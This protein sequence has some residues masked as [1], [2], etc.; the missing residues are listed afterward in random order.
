MASSAFTLSLTV[1]DLPVRRG[2]QIILSG[3]SF[4]LS[5]GEALVV[6]GPNGAGKSSLLRS[7]AGFGPAAR[8]IRFSRDGMPVD[9]DEAV[10]T[11]VHYLGHLNGLSPALSVSETLRFW[12]GHLGDGGAMPDL[13]DRFD[14]AHL[15][16]RATRHLSAGQAR[17]LAIAR[18]VIAPRPLWLLDEPDASLDTARSAL[19]ADLRRAHLARGGMIIEAAHLPT[20]LDQAGLLQLERAA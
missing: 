15:A 9:R 12:H 10:S 16:N 3:V 20:P 7:L 4:K 11:H 13:P 5:P 17:R 19:L 1:S 6:R 8:G 2:G 14:L 18:L